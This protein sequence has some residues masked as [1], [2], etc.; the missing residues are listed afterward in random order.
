MDFNFLARQIPIVTRLHAT[1][2]TG[3]GMGIGAI[4]VYVIPDSKI[5]EPLEPIA[6]PSLKVMSLSEKV[7]PRIAAA[8]P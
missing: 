7:A 3:S 5:T 6:E 4:P 1:I 8:S 2:G